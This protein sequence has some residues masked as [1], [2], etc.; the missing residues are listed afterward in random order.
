[1]ATDERIYPLPVPLARDGELLEVALGYAGAI[2]VVVDA[3]GTIVQSRSPVFDR[4]LALASYLH[5]RHRRSFRRLLERAVAVGESGEL[6]ARFIDLEHTPPI[7]DACT[8][9]AQSDASDADTEGRPQPITV[10]ETTGPIGTNHTWHR[11]WVGPRSR[12]GVGAIVLIIPSD[13]TRQARIEHQRFRALLD[14][15]EDAIFVVDPRT[16]KFVDA[17]QTACE[18]LRFSRSELLDM[19]PRDIEVD[20]PLHTREQWIDYVMEIMAVGT[21]PYQG[22]H[23][24]KDGITFPIEATWSIKMFEGDEYLLGVVRDMSEARRIADEL[25]HAEETLRV[26]DRLITVGTMAAGIVHEINNPLSYVAGNLDFLMERIGELS[27][28]VSDDAAAELLDILHEARHGAERM[29]QIAHDLRTFS[30]RDDD[31]VGAVNVAHVIDSSINIARSQIRLCAELERDEVLGL[32]VVANAPRLGQVLLNLLVNAAQAI[33]PGH[34]SRHRIYVRTKREAGFA[35]IEIE[36]TGS[37]MST[38]I[39]ERIFEPFFTTKPVG[40]GTGLG[41]SICRNIIEGFGGT[42]TVSSTLG[43]GT[44]FR[45]CLPEARPTQHDPDDETIDQISSD[46]HAARILIIEGDAAQARYLRRQLAHYQC[47]IVASGSDGVEQLLRGGYRL[48]FCGLSENSEVADFF[49]ALAEA[50]P[51]LCSRVVIVHA[52]DGEELG[53]DSPLLRQLADIS[54]RAGS[55]VAG[56]INK[57]YRADQVQ[58]VVARSVRFA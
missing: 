45:I 58:A 28:S 20:F 57:P 54:E 48:A 31:S 50:Q 51:A 8:E 6:E 23:R 34:P 42:I 41:L 13:H 16:T 27:A 30:R 44:T 36:D 49:A 15:A 10:T 33:A 29:R 25:A 3:V 17:N 35:V 12:A 40:K 18:M 37:G 2:M 4:G 43:K 56:V 46:G 47:T 24:R 5:T 22:V 11:L 14:Q 1:M 53:S 9:R 19:G 32:A 52:G 39:Q 21:L 55:G 38:E 7:A 26:S